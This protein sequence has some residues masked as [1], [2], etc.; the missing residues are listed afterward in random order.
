MAN[1]VRKTTSHVRM[2]LK[3][4]TETRNSDGLLILEYLERHRGLVFPEDIRQQ[5]LSVNFETITR[6]RRKIQSSGRYLPTDRTIIRRRRLEMVY[7]E[8]MRG[9]Q[10]PIR[11]RRPKEKFMQT[12][13]FGGESPLE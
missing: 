1:E 10:K 8:V 9:I 11:N 5:I 4:N 12:D 3:E 13:I 2:I 6:A 7:R